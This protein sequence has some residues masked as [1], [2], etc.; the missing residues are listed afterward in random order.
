MDD[1]PA[2]D[3]PA[4]LRRLHPATVI[5]SIV[6]KLWS[7]IHLIAIALLVKFF[8][9]GGENDWVEWLIAGLIGFS[10]FLSVA[11]YL[12]FHYGV[13]RDRLVICSGILERQTRTIPIDK[14]QNINLK[15]NVLHR[16]F[17]VV[18]V[19]VET[20]V[21]GE[22]E[23]DI[24]VLSVAD[25]EKL[26]RQLLPD[27]ARR[28][29]AAEPPAEATEPPMA[30]ACKDA[31]AGAADADADIDDKDSTNTWRCTLGDL[32]LLG[33]TENRAGVIVAFFM[34][35]LYTFRDVGNLMQQLAQPTQQFLERLLGESWMTAAA[36]IFVGLFVLIIAGWVVSMIY[37][38]ARYY[39][40][41]LRQRDGRLRRH[42]GLFTQVETVV[43]PR[44]IQA[45]RIQ[46]PWPRRLL[47]Y[48]S[49]FADTAGSATDRDDAGASSQLCP[50]LRKR[51]LGRF[52][53]VAF[54]QFDFDTIDWQPVSRLTFRRGLVRAALVVLFLVALLLYGDQRIANWRGQAPVGL[55]LL[56]IALPGLLLAA[57]WAWRRYRA[58]AYALSGDF[59]LARAGIW[60]RRIWIVPQSKIQSVALSQSPFQRRLALATLTIDTAAGGLLSE[61]PQIV[62]VEY[63]VARRLQDG[64][65]QTANASGLWA[66]DGV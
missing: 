4:P 51:D 54:P 47:G 23:A 46:S 38:V 24:N 64:L 14:I 9:G 33:A 39:G 66:L 3:A 10:G 53:R 25:A 21:A 1:P 12:S 2:V 27:A 6:R 45:L 57:W 59:I 11:R 26:R 17:N 49:V 19:R 62:D 13:Q 32:L 43:L 60:T 8:G 16:V 37:T 55:Q 18:D 40:F 29:V 56:W 7:M 63:E 41:T 58:L 65:S 52:C 31:V 48:V 44:R 30:R 35:L 34:G 36:V 5:I 42:Y 50:L 22:T 61:D 20:A 15:R 28:D